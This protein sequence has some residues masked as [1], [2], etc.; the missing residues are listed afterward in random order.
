MDN[1]RRMKRV[2]ARLELEYS[3]RTGEEGTLGPII[4]AVESECGGRRAP[5][6]SRSGAIDL[7]SFLEICVSFVAGVGLRKALESYLV[8]LL[9]TESAKKLGERHREAIGRW[10]VGVERSLQRLG[11]V[12]RD[13]VIGKFSFPRLNGKEQ[14]LALCIPLGRVT[15]FVV[16]NQSRVAQEA[17]D[18]LPDAVVRVLR[19]AAE[20]GLPSDAT[21][22]QLFYDVASKRWRY[23]FVPTARGF[24]HFI[25]RVIDVDT[26]REVI[27][28][29]AE[30]FIELA[31]VKSEDGLKLLVDPFRYRER[32]KDW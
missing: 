11:A 5:Y 22:V 16:V 3:Y 9:R 15:C 7:V 25:D 32:A 4:E 24:G 27:I 1:Y 23:L 30:E 14:P 19:L 12:L 31:N 17:L 8:G 2:S 10:L 21:V 6:G 20:R 13:R 29:S 18:W 26:G 28:G